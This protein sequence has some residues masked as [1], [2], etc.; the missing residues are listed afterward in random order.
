[1]T[2]TSPQRGRAF[3]LI[4]ILVVIAI[5]AVLIGI[6]LPSLEK[7]RERANNVSCA[8]NLSQIGLALLIYADANHGQYPRT[9][10]APAAPLSFGTNAGAADPFGP[11]GPK[12]NDVTAALFLLARVERVPVKVFCD[13][14][15]DEIETKPDPATDP[16]SRSNFTDYQKNLA[17]SYANPY[18]SQAAADAGY[19]LKNRMNPALAVA[20]DLNPG[21]AGKN[22]RNHEG[23]GQNVLYADNHV[24]W[25]DTPKCGVANDDIYSN[26]SGVV[27]ASPVDATDSVL[28]PV[29]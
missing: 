3:T 25:T 14:Y 20:A 2:Q 19:Q 27:Q 9:V 29:D 28:L 11:A 26:K 18:P 4:E 7:A 10:Y 17:Y 16:M 12:P 6:L 13:P 5:I 23:R 1:M 8:A 21:V 15:T 24:E 22:S